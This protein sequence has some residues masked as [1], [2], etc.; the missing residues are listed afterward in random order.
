MLELMPHQ[1]DAVES[2]AP[3]KIL[4][5]GVGSGKSLTVLHYYLKDHSDKRLIVI[6]TAKKRDSLDWQKE[7][8]RLNI[9]IERSLAVRDVLTVDSW[10]NIGSYT[11]VQDC[12][13][14]FDEQRAVGTGAWVKSFLKI[15][16]K[17]DWVLLSATPGDTWLDYV[18]V[19][20]ANGLYRNVSQFRD[21]HVVYEPFRHFPKIKE[22]K[23]VAVLEKY[24]NM[25]LV[26][27][28]YERDVK[29]TTVEVECGYDEKAFRRVWVDR[30]HIFEDRPITDVAEMF[31]VARIVDNSDP[32]RLRAVREILKEHPRIIVF[33]SWDFELDILRNL[34]SE[35]PYAEWNGKKH[36]AI[37]ETDSWV[38]VVHYTSGSEGWNCT[39]TDTIVHYSLTYSYK[40]WKQSKGRTD[41]LDSPFD[42]L[43]YFELASNS[44][45]SRAVR[46]SL[47][48]KKSF[49]ERA[50]AYRNLP[51][52]ETF[53]RVN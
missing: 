5:G 1:K 20:V 14:V 52:F 8:T 25:L 30:W 11:D 4:W 46:R 43:F 15:A 2:L 33:Y 24:R 21:E 27:M 42:E 34:A 9:G 10:N 3:G 16:K 28:K 53:G 6:T 13:F 44:P 51:D 37:P 17:N 19:F 39:E 22:F 49:N 40:N 29:R 35:Y 47:G 7:A 50:W 41:R 32:S 31:R 48:S 18:P 36:Q 12:F 45:V 23:N 26:E 38:Y